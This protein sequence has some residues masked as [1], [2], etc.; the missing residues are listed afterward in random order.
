[1]LKPFYCKPAHYAQVTWYI[2]Y[3][4]LLYICSIYACLSVNQPLICPLIIA[5]ASTGRRHLRPAQWGSVVEVSVPNWP[6][7]CVACCSFN[8]PAVVKVCTLVHRSV[9]QSIIHSFDSFIYSL[10]SS[11]AEGD[12]CTVKPNLPGV[13][14]LSSQCEPHVDKYIKRGILTGQEVPSCGFG[15]LEEIVCC[16]VAE[17]CPGDT[18]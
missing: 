17:C 13:C 18:R 4:V 14:R 9:S 6:A 12:P 1:M 5:V 2:V 10:Y 15:T 3:P 11:F 7:C 16:P 8:S